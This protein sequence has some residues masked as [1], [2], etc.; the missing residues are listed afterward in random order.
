MSIMLILTLA[1][2]AASVIAGLALGRAVFW[3]LAALFGLVAVAA[4]GWLV[5]ARWG[6][7]IVAA[8]I[9]VGVATASAR[10]MRTVA[11]LAIAGLVG[12]FAAGLFASGA[13]ASPAASPSPSASTSTTGLAQC[14]AD[15]VTQYMTAQGFTDGQYVIGEER[16]DESL[17][18]FAK[19][20]P[21][22]FG[23]NGEV[24]DSRAKLAEAFTSAEPAMVA[25]SRAQVAKFI[26]TYTTEQVLDANNWEVVQL[27]VPAE[28]TGNTGYSDGTVVKAGAHTSTSGDAYWVFVDPNTCSVPVGTK[29]S[30]GADVDPAT[31]TTEKPVGMVRVGCK[32]PT[33]TLQP[34]PTPPVPPTTPTCPEGQVVNDNGV[35]VTPKS[36]NPHDYRQ[37]GDDGAGA[38]VGAGSRPPSTVD[39]P[40]S[41]PAEVET[42]V[43]NPN[44]GVT[45]S[46]TSTPGSQTGGQ[47]AGT[48]AG[49]GAGTG[50]GTGNG[51]PETYPSAAPSNEGGSNDGRVSDDG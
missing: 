20:G 29:T 44:T 34:R 2:M 3:A 22:A 33:D 37:P 10:F 15:A 46:S 48:E 18:D 30:T 27:L 4:S 21:L 19:A 12:T 32:N 9:V 35:C 51:G 5:A 23:K 25:V 17:P 49:A 13:P 1:A 42:G 31:P 26:G 7:A 41:D 50:N 24:I 43:T 47:A 36:S 39:G 8:L 6:V 16:L 38:D 11:G 40:A 28:A 45:D 14:R